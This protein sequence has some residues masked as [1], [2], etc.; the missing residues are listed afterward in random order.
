[1]I[2]GSSMLPE[3]WVADLTCTCTN[4]DAAPP[5]PACLSPVI[6][7]PLKEHAPALPASPSL[8]AATP[9]PEKAP[10]EDNGGNGELAESRKAANDT[11]ILSYRV[12]A[13]LR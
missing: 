6:S 3:P 5:H 11:Q 2:V 4:A 13:P 1:M 9:N 7:W 8:R 10:T 12:F